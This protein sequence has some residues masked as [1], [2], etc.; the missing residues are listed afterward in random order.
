MN[1]GTGGHHQLLSLLELRSAGCLKDKRSQQTNILD[2]TISN[3]GKV[4]ECV[5]LYGG[6][7]EITAQN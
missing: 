4:F 7:T 5:L 6:A 2:E 1:S 3:V